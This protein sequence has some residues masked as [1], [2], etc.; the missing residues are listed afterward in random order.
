M[1][2]FSSPAEALARQ[3]IVFWSSI[4]SIEFFLSQISPSLDRAFQL[5]FCATLIIF[6]RV[7]IIFNS[8]DYL[9]NK[10]HTTSV[11]ILSP[12]VCLVSFAMCL[13]QLKS[14]DI[15]LFRPPSIVDD[16]VRNLWKLIRINLCRRRLTWRATPS[17]STRHDTYPCCSTASR[18]RHFR[19]HSPARRRMCASWEYIHRIYT[20]IVA[21]STCV[22]ALK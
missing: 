3:F 22:G 14:S 7:K 19:R 1:N 2:N 9:R 13:S 8:R 16:C 12:L 5:V 17:R 4:F 15:L 20:E 6:K 11:F 21:R 18:P 10:S